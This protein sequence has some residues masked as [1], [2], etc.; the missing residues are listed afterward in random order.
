MTRRDEVVR[1]ATVDGRRREVR[2]TV[3]EA[4]R[5]LRP[6]EGGSPV[7]L[8]SPAGETFHVA[9]GTP[10]HEQLVAQGAV[11]IELPKGGA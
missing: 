7:W 3:H 6:P 8:R 2:C 10:E 4:H 9:E 5:L 11:E 1:V